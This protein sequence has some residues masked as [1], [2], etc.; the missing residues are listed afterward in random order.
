[1]KILIKIEFRDKKKFTKNFHAGQS[2]GG[3][4]SWEAVFRGG[5]F[6]RDNFPRR[7]FSGRNFPLGNFLGGIF[8]AVIFP[9]DIFPGNIYPIT[10]INETH[11]VRCYHFFIAEIIV[12]SVNLI[13]MSK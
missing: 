5:S 6:P 13:Q 9:G 7:K 8:P 12:E 1:M 4:F 11:Q 2:S 3:Q 10:R